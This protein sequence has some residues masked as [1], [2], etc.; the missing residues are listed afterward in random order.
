MFQN[1]LTRE[2]SRLICGGRKFL[3]CVGLCDDPVDAHGDW[4]PP[5]INDDL[6]RK[7]LMQSVEHDGRD[8]ANM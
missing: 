2:A 1:F 6:R 4:M 3:I 5:G 8:G 7:W